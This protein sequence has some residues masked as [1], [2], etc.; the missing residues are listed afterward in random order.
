MIFQNHKLLTLFNRYLMHTC[1][2]KHNV[3]QCNV[4][5]VF[6]P[7]NTFIRIMNLRI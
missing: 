1:I 7:F 5:D 2:D 4:V 6:V 3:C